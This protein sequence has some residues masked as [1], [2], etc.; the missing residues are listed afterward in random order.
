MCSTPFRSAVDLSL[1][2]G[3]IRLHTA[4]SEDAPPVL[5]LHGAMLDTAVL[6][7]WHVAPILAST[8]RVLAID[9]PRHG[10]SRPWTQPVTQEVCERIIDELLEHV[11]IQRIALVGLSMGAGVSIGYA[12][13]HPHRVSKLVLSAPGGLDAKRP[14]QFL[15]WLMLRMPFALR[16]TTKYLASRPSALRTMM[17]KNLTAG[18]RTR[19][20]EQI[21]AL[22]QEEAEAK[23][24]HKEQ[25]LDDWQILSYGPWAMRLNHLPQLH[26]LSAPSLWLRGDSDSLVGQAEM[27]Q[28]VAAAPMAR[29]ETIANAGHL[30][31]LDQPDRFNELVT[32]FLLDGRSSARPDASAAR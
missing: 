22:V 12:L 5:L 25:A 21:L 26:R 27:E 31:T 18:D 7:W 6:T 14:A 16:W 29:L 1:A 32:G 10:G 9:L 23:A 24:R 8:H 15:T 13:N 19:D 2:A 4:G 17:A 11:R 30:L 28:A 20:F 3:P